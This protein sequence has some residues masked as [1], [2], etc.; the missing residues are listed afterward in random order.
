MSRVIADPLA[1]LRTWVI[2]RESAGLLRRLRPRPA[3]EPIVDLAGNDYLGLA[4]DARVIN[5]AAEA[6]RT[7]GVGS[8]GS[9]LVTGSTEL[10]ATLENELARHCSSEAALVFS[11]GYLANI[12]ASAALSGP[13]GLVVSD[14]HNHASVIDACRLSRARVAGVPRHG[15][16]SVDGVLGARTEEAAVVVTDAI[17]SVDGDV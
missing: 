15:P 1:R 16:G 6:I 2:E 11:S 3:T 13:D 5:A 7:W 12:G 9:R 4:R 14:A 10:H 17:F 8:T